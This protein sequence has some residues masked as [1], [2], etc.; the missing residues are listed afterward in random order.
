M[1]SLPK[2]AR[3][4]CEDCG[5]QLHLQDEERTWARCRFCNKA[6]CFDCIRYVGTTV[7][8]LFMNYVEVMRT[9]NSCYIEKG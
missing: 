6:I 9:C 5:R 2:N 7:S 4:E 3:L 1:S 8:G